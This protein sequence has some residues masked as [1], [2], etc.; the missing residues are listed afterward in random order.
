MSIT[1]AVETYR[2]N[3]DAAILFAMPLLLSIILVLLYPYPTFTSLG[4]IF[5]RV[6]SVEDLGIFGMGMTA[7]I[8]LGSILLLGTSI[9][10]I[11][12]I[13]K[14]ERMNHK[15]RYSLFIEAIRDY[16]ITIS[17]FYLL[18][19]LLLEGVQLAVYLL[20]IEGIIYS[21]VS[22]AV[23]YVLF[24]APFAMV[25]DDY[26][27]PRGISAGIDH[28]K[29]KPLDPLKW[30]VLIMAINFIV[31]YVFGLFMDYSLAKML[32]TIINGLVLLPFMIV[33][34]AHMYV[35][36]YPLTRG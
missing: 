12:L 29:T 14:E 25:I 8:L 16:T 35:D 21:I 33:Y 23:S 15:I 18:L 5:L 4:G 3:Y 13:V 28:L 6:V 26:S 36:K 31:V 19:F 20:G 7:S 27:I 2:K 30:F 17:I 1:K 24:F 11:S 22:L 34:G 10:A 32:A 9:S